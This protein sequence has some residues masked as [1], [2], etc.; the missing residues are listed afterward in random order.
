MSGGSG[1]VASDPAI[2][3]EAGDD[4]GA[5]EEDRDSVVIAG[6]SRVIE[7]RT[8]PPDSPPRSLRLT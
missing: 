8:S 6:L 1:G 3:R 7:V 5:A 4:E 2:R